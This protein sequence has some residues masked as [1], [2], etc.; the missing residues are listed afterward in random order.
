MAFVVR[1][2][3]HP[4]AVVRAG[5]DDRREAAADDVGVLQ[6]V[7][8]VEIQRV[9]VVGGEVRR[10]RPE[11]S[12]P[13][14]FAFVSA[15]CRILRGLFDIA[16]GLFVGGEEDALAVGREPGVDVVPVAGGE[17]VA[18]RRIGE[19]Q[20]EEL[21]VAIDDRRIDEPFAVRREDRRAVEELV[22]GEVG[23]RAAGDVVDVNVGN[24]CP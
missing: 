19:V 16:A 17:L 11:A 23:D 5:E 24:C 22:V 1:R 20:L 2:E 13:R 14:G 9:D 21:R 12:R 15:F 6:Q 4:L 10:D 7:A 3:D 8:A 18:L